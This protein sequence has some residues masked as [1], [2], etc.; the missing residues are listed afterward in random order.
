MLRKS[1]T[2]LALLAV[3]SVAQAQAD[4]S[5]PPQL[6]G[7]W[8]WGGVSAT[9]F[10]DTATGTWAAPSGMGASYTFAPDG[11]YTYAGLIQ[12]GLYG[13]LTKFFIYRSGEAYRQDEILMLVPSVHHVKSEDNC[14]PSYNYE[15]DRSLEPEYLLWQLG[16][17]DDGRTELGLL[18][19]F[20]ND[21]ELLDVAD[22]AE[23]TTFWAE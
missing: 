8:S 1:L 20:L 19:L 22:D 9:R 12:S 17:S 23:W 7:A 13:C 15:E 5:L 4:L 2:S 18:E 3:I 16:R 11:T 21:E 10:Y 6:L 14:S